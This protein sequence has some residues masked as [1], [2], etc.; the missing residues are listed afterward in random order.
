M[1]IISRV[2]CHGK[3]A[4]ALAHKTAAR[5]ACAAQLSSYQPPKQPKIFDLPDYQTRKCTLDLQLVGVTDR[6]S[7]LQG[8]QAQERARL[9]DK[10]TTLET[11][12]AKAERVLA[13]KVH[14][15]E[16]HAWLQVLKAERQACAAK[17]EE[18]DAQIALYEA[19]THYKVQFLAHAVNCRFQLARF[20]L[21][22][23]Q[24]NGGLADCCEVVAD[25]VPY[26]DLNH[27]VQV[28]VG[29]DIIHTLSVHYGLRVPLV[30]DNAELQSIPTQ[31]IRLVVSAPDKTL[32]IEPVS[33]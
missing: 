31:V 12:R 5:D 24:V 30:V 27:A 14:L 15:D 6:I 23:E 26:V 8:G 28:N 1:S 22:H 17:L 29:I 7:A 2:S 13:G 4:A 16:M 3:G 11:A 18:L 10:L 21:F 25:G 32:R 19:F 9:L 33:F 20:R